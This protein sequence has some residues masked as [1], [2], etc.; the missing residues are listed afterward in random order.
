[1]IDRFYSEYGED[2]W[3]YENLR[4]W[5]PPRGVYLDVGCG[6]PE[7]NSNTAFLRDQGWVGMAVDGNPAYY[8]HWVGRQQFCAAIFAAASTARFKIIE[9]NSALS[10]VVDT[11]DVAEQHAVTLEYFL[12]M[13]FLDADPPI[14]RID[15]MSIDI[16]GREFEVFETMEWKKWL[17][18]IIV[19]EYATLGLD[20]SVSEDYRLRD[21]LL[22]SG[23]YNAVHKTVANIIYALK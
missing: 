18:R 21:L 1:M 17:P 20:G 7:R 23:L 4:E 12:G 13:T 22:G 14:R 10:R 3:I 8:R 11:E 5:M 6:H 2:K 15:F 16:E 19:A 9:D